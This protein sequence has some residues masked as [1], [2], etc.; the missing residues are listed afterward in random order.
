VNQLATHALSGQYVP[1]DGRIA[2]SEELAAEICRR[3]SAGK[4]LRAVCRDAD[5]PCMAT[6]LNWL[7]AYPDFVSQYARAREVLHEHWAQEIIE[8]S[9]TPLI[10]VKTKTTDDGVETVEGDMIE[11]RRL[12]VDARKWLLSK[13]APRKYGDKI[14]VTAVPSVPQPSEPPVTLE[15]SE[16]QYAALKD[17]RE[18][19]SNT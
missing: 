16:R 10:G 17:G 19:E 6:V 3:M 15:E 8:I 2:Y 1:R 9:D 12:Q 11:H 5:M 13:L 18:P 7:R 14:E 4:S